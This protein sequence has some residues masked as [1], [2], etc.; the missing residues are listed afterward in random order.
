MSLPANLR[1]KRNQLDAFRR[2]IKALTEKEVLVGFPQ[3]SAERDP[4]P[5]EDSTPITN[6]ALGYIHNNGAPEQN[7]PQREF[8]ESGIASVRDELIVLMEDVARHIVVHGGD[9]T[10]VEKLLMRVGDKAE[11]ALK[12]KVNEGIP[13]PLA[14]STLQE[15]ARRGRKGAKKELERRAAGEDPSTEFAKPLIDTTQM[16]NAIK[17]VIRSTKQRR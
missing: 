4:E 5:G 16:R 9:E 11:L 15:R 2:S 8:M 1:L 7:I 14:K 12:N 13:P 3:E 6:A 10:T 17:Y